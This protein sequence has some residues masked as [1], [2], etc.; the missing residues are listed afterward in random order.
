MLDMF[1]ELG[2]YY[3]GAVVLLTCLILIWWDNRK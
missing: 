1:Q 2:W 3:S